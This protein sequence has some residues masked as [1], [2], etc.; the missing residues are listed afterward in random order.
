MTTLARGQLLA[1]GESYTLDL[2]TGPLQLL[3]RLGV[4]QRGTNAPLTLLP[5]GW[6]D[7]PTAAKFLCCARHRHHQ[8]T[9]PRPPHVAPRPPPTPLRRIA[10]HLAHHPRSH[11]RPHTLVH[12]GAPGG[13]E[14]L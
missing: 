8:H 5:R 1:D 9:A 3:A 6:P 14:R 11:P 13:D 10:A 7:A 12:R 4:P 2:A